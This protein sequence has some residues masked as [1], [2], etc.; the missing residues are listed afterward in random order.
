MPSDKHTAAVERR[1]DL[2]DELTSGLDDGR[3]Y[4]GFGYRE[5]DGER[6]MVKVIWNHEIDNG[7]VGYPHDEFTDRGESEQHRALAIAKVGKPSPGHRQ[8]T[9]VAD[10]GASE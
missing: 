1:A 4:T 2:A 10:G 8:S 5:I 7:G 3:H 6:R 9:L